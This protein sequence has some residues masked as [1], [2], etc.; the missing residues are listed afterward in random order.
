[1]LNVDRVVSTDGLKRLT[2]PTSDWITTHR[3]GPPR[4]GWGAVGVLGGV[5]AGAATRR[6]VSVDPLIVRYQTVVD[7]TVA[8]QRDPLQSSQLLTHAPIAADGTSGLWQP[9]AGFRATVRRKDGP[10]ANRSS[11]DIF[12]A[13]AFISQSD[14]ADPP[15]GRWSVS[16]AGQLTAPAAGNGRQYASFGDLTWNHL[17]LHVRIVPN[18][19]PAGVAVG[20]AGG[21]PVPQAI[22]A[23]IEPDA[24]GVALVLRA[25]AGGAETELGR[26]SVTSSDG[27]V[28]LHVTA[29]DDVV[30]AEVGTVRVEGARGA[31]RD[32]R[33]ALV[34]AGAAA[35]LGVIVDG[36]DMY[37]YDFVSSRYQSFQEH[38][39]SFDGTL[40]ALAPGAA[41][42]TPTSVAAILSGRSADIAAAMR[43]DADPQQRQAL[44]TD[45]VSALALP[46][47]QRRERVTISR[48]VE[49]SG[50]V[51]LLIEG[52]E[53]LPLSTDVTASLVHQVVIHHWPPY[54]GENAYTVR[55]ARVRF[56]A[57][58]ISALLS[59]AAA[60]QPGDQLVRVAQTG[61]APAFAIY[62]VPRRAAGAVRAVGALRET[63]VPAPGVRPEL[64]VLRGAPDGALGI[65]RPG[66][67]VIATGGGA[68]NGFGVVTIDVL[69]A[70]TALSNGDETTLLLFPVDS[71]GASLA[72]HSGGYTLTLR[73]QRT[74]WRTSVSDPSAVYDQS[75]AIALAW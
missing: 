48:I 65:V 1:V 19:A 43:A 38:V 30:R 69:V 56:D 15:A 64:D 3:A 60:F 17:Q 62:D 34:A 51:G 46:L 67:G 37:R 11:F 7:S 33:V 35:F 14:G 23:T 74:R 40:S 29:F 54:G 25:R 73:V 28:T 6:A 44:A 55:L 50:T 27:V 5:I 42:G 9:T 24:G 21:S 61:D 32:G 39:D 4:K 57:G 45:V 49:A 20:V 47:R 75:R 52:P 71:S 31:I 72:L 22:L 8:C 13:G 59:D 26:Q 63:V 70:L 2:V 18:G 12:D 58:S 66:A 41:G 53:P 36:L 16:A 10:Y 68:G